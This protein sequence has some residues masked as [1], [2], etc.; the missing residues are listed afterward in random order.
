MVAI[1]I[2][3][4]QSPFYKHMMSSVSL[5][6]ADL[7]IMGE[8]IEVGIKNGK[9]ALD[10]NLVANLNEYGSRCGIR[11]ERRANL[12]PIVY[13]QMSQSEKSNQDMMKD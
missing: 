3:T 11:T 8:R 7:I 6:F 5:N 9:I 12:H 2:N 1:F 13:P 10:P 4:L